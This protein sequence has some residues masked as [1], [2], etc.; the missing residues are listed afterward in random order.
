[1]ILATVQ[2]KQCT[3]HQHC[4]QYI[5][6]AR[7]LGNEQL[8]TEVAMQPNTTSEDL[9]DLEVV[10]EV[11][12]SVAPVGKVVGK[13]KAALVQVAAKADQAEVQVLVRA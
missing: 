3:H 9:E 7:S 12:V 4:P 13:E 5:H 1:M 11:G 10:A 2:Q 8:R 6:T